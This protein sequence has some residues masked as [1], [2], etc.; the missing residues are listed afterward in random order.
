MFPELESVKKKKAPKRK[1]LVASYDWGAPSSTETRHVNSFYDDGWIGFLNLDLIISEAIEM[2]ASD[3]H[4]YGGQDIYFTI[5][6][7]VAPQEKYVRLDTDSAF[8]ISKA[9]LTNL[10]YSEFVRDRDYDFS[11]TVIR[12]PYRGR[13]LRGHV[14]RS[15]GFEY[16]VFRIISDEIPTTDSLGIEQEI[17]DWMKA[18]EGLALICGATGTGKSTTLAS[19]IRE[20]QLTE[21][22]KIITIEKPIEYVYPVDGRALIAQREV[23]DDVVTFTSGLTAAMREAPD[24][25]LIGEVRNNEE[26][27]E[28]IRA[29]E[30]GHMAIST[31][32]TNSVATTINRIQGLFEGAERLR[33]LSTLADTLQGLGNQTLV[34]TKDGKG[35]V[36]CRELLT[37]N[38]EIR[39]LI[40]KGD[41][42]GIRDYQI[43]H[44]ITM[45]YSLVRAALRGECTI[46][47][48]RKHSSRRG[49][50]ADALKE[51]MDA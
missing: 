50:F 26:V 44:K 17:K 33:I 40:A 41:V 21:P 20:V 45:E 39:D 14:G 4:I 24:M 47:E 32:H 3:I 35:R 9:L 8:D 23:G 19:V 1:S 2:G 38:S 34:K 49:E 15:L 42:K 28:L 13:R 7:D 12:G 5:N 11:Y 10:Q 27:S 48:A 18:P 22:K 37:V 29:A 30:T 6:G 16:F 43:K 51:L 36:A 25:I 31:M 46:E